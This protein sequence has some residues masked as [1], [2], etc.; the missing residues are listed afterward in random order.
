MMLEALFT[1]FILT[2]Q[3]EGG[4][5]PIS[6]QSKEVNSVRKY[7]QDNIQILFPEVENS[8]FI[9]ELAQIQIVAGMNLRLHIKTIKPQ[10]SFI[11]TLYVNPERNITIKDIEKDKNTRP[12]FG[13]YIWHDVSPIINQTLQ[14][15]VQGNIIV[16]RTKIERGM[17]T[18]IIFRDPEEKVYSAIFTINP[19]TKNEE[20]IFIYE[21]I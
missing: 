1:L 7:F 19:K 13:Q 3:I 17:K 18:H 8:D 15:L 6:V 10:I 5:K 12:M 2:H 4:W 14:N 21:I 11:I 16:Y 20:L 9:I